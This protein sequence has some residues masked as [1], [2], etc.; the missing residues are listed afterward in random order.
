MEPNLRKGKTEIMFTFRGSQSREFR[1]KYFSTAQGLTVVSEHATVQ[2][3]VVSR[4]LHLGGILHHRD[5]D[6]VEVSRRL[7]IAHQAFTAHRRI[8]YHNCQIQWR[9]R[10]EIFVT[11]ILSKLVYGLESWT[12]KSQKVKTQFYSGVMSLYR[13]LLKLPHDMHIT[14]LQLLARAGLPS[15]DELLRSSRLRYFGTLHR[16][17]RAAN[18]GVIA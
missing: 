11:L 5:I 3:S 7:A 12:L 4:Y 1:R 2:V 6:R 14:D 17:G 15:P 16:C 13:R 9:K 18:W 8:L 10:R